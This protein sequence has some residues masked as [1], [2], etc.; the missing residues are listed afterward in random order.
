MLRSL[1]VLW[2]RLGAQHSL[3]GNVCVLNQIINIHLMTY[4]CPFLTTDKQKLLLNWFC[5]HQNTASSGIS[6]SKARKKGGKPQTAFQCCRRG[7]DYK[8][9][10]CWTWHSSV[11][12]LERMNC[13]V[14]ST[15]INIYDTLPKWCREQLTFHSNSP[16][17]SAQQNCSI[18]SDLLFKLCLCLHRCTERAVTSNNK[19]SGRTY[20]L[21]SHSYG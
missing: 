2:K 20:P 19:S 9:L 7:T 15:W 13:L 16:P 6:L 4:N 21:A 8:T 14:T 10:L 18:H 1:P 3:C 17:V 5:K 12:G 11:A